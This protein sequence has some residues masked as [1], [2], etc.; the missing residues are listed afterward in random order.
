MFGVPLHPMIV[1]FPMVLVTLLPIFALVS[2]WAIRGGA[3][4][5]R[6]WAATLA[7]AGALALSAFAA[8]ETGEAEEERVESVVAERAMHA[9]EE[10][11]ERFL[12]LSVL[13]TVVAAG[14]LARGTIGRAARVVTVMGAA[15]LVVAGIQVGHA[16]GEL[17]YRH[18]AADAYVE[19]GVAAEAADRN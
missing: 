15:A 19:S 7:L 10:A 14:G 2:L 6:A 16:G 12:L 8:V 4:P 17:V 13:L 5:P 9:H 1:H 11:G 3:R 18:G